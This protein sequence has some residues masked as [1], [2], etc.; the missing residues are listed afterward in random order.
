[1][2]EGLNLLPSVAKFQAA[3]INLKKKIGLAMAIFLGVWILSI[4]IVFV[5][6][7]INNFLLNKDKKQNTLALD[8][9]KTLVTNVVISKRNKYQAKLVGKVLKERFEYGASIDKITNLFSENIALENFEIKEKKQFL[10]KY[11]LTNGTN[12]VEIEE[13]VRDINLGLMSDFKSAKLSSI[14]IDG[15]WTVEM[16]VS[17]I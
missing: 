1:M 15:I 14:K 11:S 6:I 12:L 7:G 4:I 2:K 3:R 10:L 16:E 8:R 5:W 13:K 17:L 9:Y